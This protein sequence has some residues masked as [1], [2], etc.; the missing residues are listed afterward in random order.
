LPAWFG[1]E[2]F[3]VKQKRINI[4]A[5]LLLVVYGTLTLV[6]VPL[7]QHAVYYVDAPQYQ[8]VI[9]HHGLDCSVCTFV[10]QST[11]TSLASEHGIVLSEQS[12]KPSFAQLPKEYT[13][14]FSK[15]Y[16]RRGPPALL[17]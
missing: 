14:Q 8:S 7:H 13:S 9:T 2:K 12:G 16:P 1:R 15:E 5:L 11:G 10:S 3:N 17:S 6:A 4:L